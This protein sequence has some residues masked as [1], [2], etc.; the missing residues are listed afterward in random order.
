MSFPILRETAYNFILISL[1]FYFP[2]LFF[3]FNK[4][5]EN[6]CQCSFKKW[7]IQ[8]KSFSMLQVSWQVPAIPGLEVLCAMG[9]SV[10]LVF[11]HWFLKA[12]RALGPPFILTFSWLHVTFPDHFISEKGWPPS[13]VLPGALGAHLVSVCVVWF[14]FS[15]VFQAF[16]AVKL[17]WSN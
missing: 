3:F 1:V 5:V 4:S 11:L 16:Q 6:S 9:L 10:R 13:L 14:N 17:R 12:E 15:A 7:L 2:N 8:P